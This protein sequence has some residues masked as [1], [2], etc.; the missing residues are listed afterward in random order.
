[1]ETID[2]SV[3]RPGLRERKKQQTRET[4]ERVALELFAERGFDETT[5]A[6][7]AEAADVSPRTIFSYF[8]SK[9]DILFCQESTQ[10]ER[11]EQVLEQRPAGTTTA[12]VLREFLSS[13]GPHDEAALLRKKV[14]MANPALG[15][16][17]RARFESLLTESI[18]KDLG[19][20]ADDIRSRLIAASMNAA[21][22]TM[23]E[24][25]EAGGDA[26]NPEQVTQTLDEVLEFLRGGLAALDRS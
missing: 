3:P 6:D 15:V 7:I 22:T 18:A 1:M 24:Q 12:D 26:P 5:I 20:G 21:F 25:L 17:M 23:R 4:I 14:L 11:L 19:G 16:R 8:E 13:L 2:T 10:F 9:E